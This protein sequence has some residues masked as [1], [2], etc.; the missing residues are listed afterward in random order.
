MTAIWNLLK[1]A[2][3]HTS[4]GVSQWL[5]RRNEMLW[6]WSFIEQCI[7]TCF[8]STPTQNYNIIGVYNQNLGWATTTQ[9]ALK[10][11]FWVLPASV[12]KSTSDAF[13][14]T[15]VVGI[16]QAYHTEQLSLTL[17]GLKLTWWNDAIGIAS[18]FD[19][20]RIKNRQQSDLL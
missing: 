15:E 14:C 2:F 17:L 7:W 11:R 12:S 19:F 18:I 13:W 20:Q 3:Q 9:W 6:G 10:W 8:N 16:L 1:L 5:L 4:L